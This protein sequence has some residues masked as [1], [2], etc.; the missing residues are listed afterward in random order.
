MKLTL[1]LPVVLI[2]AITLVSLSMLSSCGGGSGSGQKVAG[3]EDSGDIKAGQAGENIKIKGDNF[4]AELNV[5]DNEWSAEIPADVPKFTFGTIDHTSATKTGEV[6][7]WGIFY[8]DVR[9]GALEG[10][11]GLLK[12]AG[13]K[14]IR[15]TM[16]AQGSVTGEK[17]KIVVN[18]VVSTDMTHL[19]VQVSR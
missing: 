2:W 3:I 15:T 4:E 14:T 9:A 16:D 11:D 19:S 1:T 6:T 13:F 8:K 5:K 12:K 10:Y 7:G 18:L 17:D